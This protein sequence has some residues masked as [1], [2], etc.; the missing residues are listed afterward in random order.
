MENAAIGKGKQFVNVMMDTIKITL[1]VFYDLI[2]SAVFFLLYY[3]YRFMSIFTLPA[4]GYYLLNV[5]ILIAIGL[6]RISVL[7]PSLAKKTKVS[8]DADRGVGERGTVNNK[9]ALDMAADFAADDPDDVLC[10]RTNE[11]VNNC[12][13]KCNFPSPMGLFRSCLTFRK[14]E[15]AP[16]EVKDLWAKYYI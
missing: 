2:I 4:L 10:T 6:F 13:P 5:V 11:N 12:V 16:V 15:V 14:V 3:F 7:L 1:K 9:R 8:L